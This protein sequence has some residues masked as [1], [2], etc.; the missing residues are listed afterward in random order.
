MA[1]DGRPEGRWTLHYSW[2]ELPTATLK[3]W[4]PNLVQ[5]GHVTISEPDA[6]GYCRAEAQTEFGAAELRWIAAR[7]R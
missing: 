7:M 2:R 6:L 5:L 4:L 3:L 1:K